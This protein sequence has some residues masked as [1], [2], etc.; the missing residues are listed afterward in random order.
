MDAKKQDILLGYILIL[1]FILSEW[2]LWSISHHNV[3]G[4]IVLNVVFGLAAHG[5]YTEH[6]NKQD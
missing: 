1:S 4:F 3:I 6:F 2:V 5:A